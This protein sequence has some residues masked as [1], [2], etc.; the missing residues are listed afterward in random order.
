MIKSRL[1]TFAC[2]LVMTLVASASVQAARPTTEFELWTGCEPTQI[3]SPY[4]DLST[5]TP[6]FP[7]SPNDTTGAA[8]IVCPG[9]DYSYLSSDEGEPFAQ[10]LNELGISAFV[11]KYRLSVDG[12]HYPTPMLDAQRAIRTVRTHA[13]DWDLDPNR[14]GIIGAAAG[15]HLAALT[16]VHYDNGNTN[17]TDPNE[18]VSCRPDLG[19]LCYPVITMSDPNA[20]EGSRHYLLGDEATKSELLDYLSAEQHVSPNTP[21]AF[22]M[23][24]EPDPNIPVQNATLFADA[25]EAN[26]VPYELHLYEFEQ[27]SGGRNKPD[28]VKGVGLGSDPGDSVNYHAWTGECAHWL[29]EAGFGLPHLGNI[30]ALGD[31]ITYGAAVPSAI[32]GGYRDPLYEN[33][34]AKGYDFQFVGTVSTN[35]STQLTKAGQQYHDGHSAYAIADFS[36]SSRNYSGLYDEVEDWVDDLNQKPDLILLMIGINDLNQKNDVTGAADRLDLLITRLFT[37]LPDVRLL[38]SSV[39]DADDDNDYRHVP[40]NTDLQEPINNYNA[41]IASIVATRQGLGENIEFVDMHAGLTL[42]DLS[43]G[44]HPS[45]EGYIKM[46]DIWTD[47]ID[48][49]SPGSK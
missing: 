40:P 4:E 47:A 42:D 43:D 46:A 45:E 21:P 23:T 8:M 26:E 38:V 1:F 19:V 29:Y 49:N 10:W 20:H 37:L 28:P 24:T 15:G 17:S 12:Y 14:I 3:N 48:V 44:L 13:S 22:I 36:I 34:V 25:L 5:L 6:Y 35:A 16:M 33:L 11:L 39:L 18:R 27:S 41:G 31:S 9:G 2:C 7:S 32:P 30:W